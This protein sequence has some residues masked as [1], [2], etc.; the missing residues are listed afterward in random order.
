MSTALGRSKRSWAKDSDVAVYVFGTQR[1][2]ANGLHDDPQALPVGKTEFLNTCATCSFRLNCSKCGLKV[3]IPSI[4]LWLP[5]V[6]GL[7]F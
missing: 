4:V 3:A 7:M 2:P 5:Y 1:K 6:A